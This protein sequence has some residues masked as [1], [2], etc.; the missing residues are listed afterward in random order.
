RIV[1][2]ARSI[3]PVAPDEEQRQG[4]LYTYWTELKGPVW[5]L[6]FESDRVLLAIDSRV[7]PT[8]DLPRRPVFKAL[9]YPEILRR[10][11]FEALIYD[12]HTIVDAESWQFYWARLPRVSFGFPDDIPDSTDARLEWIND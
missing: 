12:E 1:A 5:E 8:H 9:V 7:D 10:V 6:E 4:L 3:Q 2:E 11:L